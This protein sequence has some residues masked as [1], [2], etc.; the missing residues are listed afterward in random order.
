MKIVPPIV[1]GVAFASV[2]PACGGP[3]PLLDFR[4]FPIQ[5]GVADVSFS[6]AADAFGVADI[7]FRDVFQGVAA[8][9]FTPDSTTD[10][11]DDASDETPD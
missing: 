8:D 7:S 4:N 6:V 11:I 9:A 5:G 3:D 10:A 2:V 1:V